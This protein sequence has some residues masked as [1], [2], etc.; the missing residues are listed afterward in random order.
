MGHCFQHAASKEVAISLIAILGQQ[1]FAR[2]IDPCEAKNGINR[3]SLSWKGHSTPS[4]SPPH[5]ARVLYSAKHKE[6]SIN[7]K[8]IG[9]RIPGRHRAKYA[10]EVIPSR[11]RKRA[12]EGVNKC[13]HQTMSTCIQ[14]LL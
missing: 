4:Q 2:N 14:C 13:N 9:I 6:S 7:K 3:T 1:F 10:P 11:D 8:F 12:S 5:Q